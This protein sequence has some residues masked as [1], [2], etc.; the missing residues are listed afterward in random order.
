MHKLGLQWDQLESWGASVRDVSAGMSY[1]N[2]RTGIYRNGH[3]DKYYTPKE[4]EQTGTS[5][6]DAASEN[7][8]I[9][10]NSA[11]RSS[12]SS[13]AKSSTFTDLAD[14]RSA[15]DYRQKDYLRQANELAADSPMA[16][17]NSRMF[18]GQLS[19][20]D[21]RLAMSAFESMSDAKIFSNPRVIVSNGR[22]AKVDMTTK[23][24]NVTITANHSGDNSQYL[25]IS[26]KLDVI[27]GE[28]KFMFAKEAFF[29]WGIQLSVTPRISP[30]G[31]IS[32]AIVPTISE[33]EGVVTV[34]G[35][36]NQNYP[37]AQ[38]PIIN[39]KRLVT[40]F[41]MKD[42]STAVIGG[43]SKTK[44]G[45]VDSGIPYLRKIP[46]I[47]PKLFGWKSRGKVQ[48][49]ILV[50]VTVGIADP[51]NLPEDIGLPKNAVRGREYVEKRALE[52]G[53]RPDAANDI[54]KLDMTAVDAR[55]SEDKKKEKNVPQA[56][57]TASGTVTITPVSP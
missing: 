19:V 47:G 15:F 18:S 52:P 51:A 11:S 32:V 29:S 37:Y 30:D 1:A 49:E 53:D 25:E 38:Y 6:N 23:Y 56:E 35:A 43:L 57:S 55:R 28:D 3:T 33:Q 54:L 5:E 10:D 4:M 36:A 12:N 41:T 16:W 34:G 26:T 8:T 21:F 14:G 9:S 39:I 27:P 40:D 46:W 50:F 42:G 7:S 20:D 31:L 22:E 24:P 44:E 48:N 45:D 2:G 17:R 13:S